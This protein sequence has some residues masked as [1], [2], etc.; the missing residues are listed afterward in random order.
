MQMSSIFD[1][2]PPAAAHAARKALKQPQQQPASYLRI[3]PSLSSSS[4]KDA[5]L[6]LSAKA[7]RLK[8][9]SVNHRM[10]KAPAAAAA[11]PLR[12]LGEQG[13]GTVG[14]QLMQGALLKKKRIVNMHHKQQPGGT[15]SAAATSISGS[16]G[17]A[18]A[19]PAAKSRPQLLDASYLSDD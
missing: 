4:A 5:H 18:P 16:A 7:K 9:P 10:F 17:K 8:I 15:G 1:A 12:G 11:A 14:L 2:P 6:L 13:R 3:K 19:Q